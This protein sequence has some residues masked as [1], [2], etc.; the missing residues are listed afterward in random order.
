MSETD[1]L[2][3]DGI[4]DKMENQDVVKSV[5][6]STIERESDI[7]KQS[8]AAVEKLMKDSLIKK[9]M[10]NI[11]VVMVTF[12][13]FEKKIFPAPGEELNLE[14][15]KVYQ[16]LQR[17]LLANSSHYNTPSQKSFLN[18]SNERQTFASSVGRKYENPFSSSFDYTVSSQ[19]EKQW[20]GY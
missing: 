10:D 13:G 11:T 8:A 12:E 9:T 17:S 5:W 20:R 19:L 18:T 3:G 16:P 1:K 2:L 15:E 7:H 6:D 4:Y 14:A